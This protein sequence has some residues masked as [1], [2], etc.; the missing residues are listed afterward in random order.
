MTGCTI[1]FVFNQNVLQRGEYNR[2]QSS[3]TKFRP[4]LAGY[5]LIRTDTYLHTHLLTY[6]LVPD[7]T[8]EKYLG[9]YLCAYFFLMMMQMRQ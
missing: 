1:Y 6:C 4:S 2:K 5:V 7:I 9:E 3:K 8:E